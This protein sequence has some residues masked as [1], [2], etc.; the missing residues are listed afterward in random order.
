MATQASQLQIVRR[1]DDTR[2]FQKNLPRRYDPHMPPLFS[3]T[4]IARVFLLFL[5]INLSSAARA[6]GREWNQIHN[7]VYQLQNID[8][9]A[10]GK[11]KFQLAV[12]DFSSDGSEVNRFTREQIRALQTS[13]GGAKRVLSYMSIGEAEEYR[14]YWQADWKQ[15]P[16]A[17]LGP[18]NPDWAGNYK[19]KYWDAD[20]QKIVF[21]YEDKIID[22]GF[23]GVYLDVVDAYEFWQEKGDPQAE[24]RMVDF[25]KAIAN[26]ARLDRGIKDFAVF[27]QNDEELSSHADYVATC[28]GIGKEDLF[29]DGDKKNKASETNYSISKLNAFKDAGKPVLVIDYPKQQ[30]K[31]D[32]VYSRAI[33]KGFVPYAPRRELDQLT[34]NKGHEPD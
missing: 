18:V 3:R 13:P 28:T 9:N 1:P 26:H 27:V 31:I 6:A 11:T 34:I 8:L 16:P 17:W 10:I 29:F 2:R 20:W 33:A 14:W 15:H 30:A 25:V 19:V 12:I 32:E 21:D 4:M 23:D 5:V 7:F 24:Q 22:A